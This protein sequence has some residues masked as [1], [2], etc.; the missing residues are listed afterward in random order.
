MSNIVGARPYLRPE[1][2]GGAVLESAP[3]LHELTYTE[4]GSLALSYVTAPVIAALLVAIAAALTVALAVR[5]LR[6]FYWLAD[7]AAPTRIPLERR[8]VLRAA[9]AVAA[10]EDAQKQ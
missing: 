5:L 10:T 3:R 6:R 4:R 1:V 9:R 7:V 2:A 8:A